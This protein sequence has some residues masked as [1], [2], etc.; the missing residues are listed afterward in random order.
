[1]YADQ[2]YREGA[3]TCD[4]C[5]DRWPLSHRRTQTGGARVGALCC[6]DA[7]DSLDRDSRR[8]KASL[9]AAMLSKEEVEKPLRGP[10]GQFYPGVQTFGDGTSGEAYVTDIVVVSSGQSFTTRPIQVP[11][12]PSSVTIEVRGGENFAG[13]GTGPTITAITYGSATLSD[14][15]VGVTTAT[16]YRTAVQATG[17]APSSGP[18]SMKF[19]FS[20][21]T[22][23]TFQNVFIIP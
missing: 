4:L 8:A 19:A 9:V 10:D 7:E 11:R 1:M 20:D 23:V 21:G 16:T 17:V 3:F 5:H 14:N 12:N 2:R 18:F 13:T 22:D 6:Y 15:G